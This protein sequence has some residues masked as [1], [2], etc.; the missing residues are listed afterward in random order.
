MVVR[1]QSKGREI[2]GL[3]VGAH[4]VRRYFPKAPR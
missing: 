3:Q 2:T 4:N 1:T